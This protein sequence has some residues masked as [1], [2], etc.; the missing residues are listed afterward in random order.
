MGSQQSSFIAACVFTT[1]A[2]GL[3]VAST[4]LGLKTAHNSQTDWNGDDAKSAGMKLSLD[5]AAYR[6]SAVSRVTLSIES[7]IA[8]NPA[9]LAFGGLVGWS[10][11][12]SKVRRKAPSDNK[13]ESVQ[14]QS[15]QIHAKGEEAGAI[16]APLLG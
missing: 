6:K 13:V 3:A 4:V 8:L 7:V 14:G 12:I 5:A 16:R 1:I 15:Q 10:L 11:V 2:T 9:V